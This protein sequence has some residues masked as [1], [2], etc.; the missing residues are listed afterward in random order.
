VPGRAARYSHRR[1]DARSDQPGGSARFDEE[2]TAETPNDDESG[3]TAEGAEGA[4]EEG[5]I[6]EDDK[7]T[8]RDG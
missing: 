4:R 5:E 1:I 8:V 7:E 2:S 6:D 3:F